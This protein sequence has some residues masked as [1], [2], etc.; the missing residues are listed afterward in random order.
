MA[1]RRKRRSTQAGDFKDPINNY[2][3][4][5]YGDELEQSLGEDDVRE[6][7]T[8]LP[9]ASDVT[10]FLSQTD[11]LLKSLNVGHAVHDDER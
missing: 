10:Q 3:P 6:M 2:D 7:Q 9:D 11:A 4:P 5:E 1:T 8:T